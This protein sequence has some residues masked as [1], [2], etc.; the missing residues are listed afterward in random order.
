MQSIEEK[1]VSI[2][3]QKA[4]GIALA[5]KRGELDP[6]E[7][8]GAAKQMYKMSEKDLEDFAKT[9]HKGLPMK[10]GD[11]FKSA[12]WNSAAKHARGNIFD[13]NQDYFEWTGPNYLK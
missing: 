9:K 11:V 12:S 2:S 7:L 8:T 4:A 6:S 13:D 10:V 1:S 3:Q 5:A